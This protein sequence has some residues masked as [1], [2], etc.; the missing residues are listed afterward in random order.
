MASCRVRTAVA[1]TPTTKVARAMTRRGAPHTH[2]AQ[3]KPLPTIYNS[4]HVINKVFF[5]FFLILKLRRGP[6]AMFWFR[7]FLGKCDN[8]YFSIEDCCGVKF[9][10]EQQAGI[11]KYVG[12]SK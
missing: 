10:L 3:P 2:S 1:P 4:L 6:G 12:Q 11:L 7:S 9:N 8:M 5:S